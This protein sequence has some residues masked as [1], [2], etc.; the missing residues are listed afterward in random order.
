[1]ER[2]RN[3]FSP[4]K[5]CNL[6]IRN[7]IVLSPMGIGIYN[8]DETVADKY[9]DFIKARTDEIGFIIVTGCR[10]SCRYGK[11]KFFGCYSDSQIPSLKKLAE[12]AHANGAKIFLQ[13]LALGGTDFEEPFVPSINIP[14]FYENWTGETKPRELDNSQIKEVIQDFISGAK[15]AQMAGF[16]GV[17]LFGSEEGLISEFITPHFNR[18]EDE[19]GGSFNNMLRFPSEIIRGI[20]EECGL[21][22][23]VGFKYNAFYDIEDGI[24]LES[25]VEIAK[26]MIEAG[27]DYIHEWSFSSLNKPMSLFKYT[28]MPNLYQQRNSTIPIST[29]LKASLNDTP[30][31]AVCGILKPDEADSIISEKKADLVAIG[32]GYIAEEMWAAKS[33][34]GKMIRPCIRCHVCHHEIAI[35]GNQIVCSVNPN[36]FGYNDIVKVSEDKVKRVLV[37]G[38]GPAGI[39][40]AVTASKRDHLVTLYEKENMLGGKLVQGSIPEFKQEFKDLLDYLR[41]EINRSNVNVILGIEVNEDILKSEKPDVVVI[42]IGAESFVPEVLKTKNPN[43]M[44]AVQALNA[45]DSFKGLNIIVAGGG[46]V[47]CETAL[48]LRLKRNEV[49]I[50]E[51]LEELMK[52]DDIKHNTVVLEKMLKENGVK[53]FLNSE[54]LGISGDEVKIKN[55]SNSETSKLN[56]DLIINA[57]GFIEPVGLV[58]RFKSYATRNF[59]AVGDC[60]KYSGRLRGAINKAYEIG[61][62]I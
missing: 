16:D 61:K 6:E 39:T 28:P 53:V 49:T 31:I 40:A 46:D 52:N 38:G 44:T 54:I 9:I 45:S 56:Y 30:V 37:I 23:P 60:V 21:N 20:K 58:E 27:V 18:R 42:A 57:T 43:V 2:Y 7:R 26:K 47:G 36:V 32:R 62:Q 35:L 12:T 1:M 33:K 25:G 29:N 10:V 34:S 5:I 13:I 48:V 41:Q 17:E 22:F 50:I 51:P 3:L 14:A 8:D 15:R 24:S 19:Y 55:L 4:I 59:S 11:I